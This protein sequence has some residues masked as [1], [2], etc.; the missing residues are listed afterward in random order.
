[1]SFRRL[2]PLVDLEGMQKI[3]QA[4]ILVIGCGGVGSYVIEAL[5]RSGVGT[6][7]LVD[8]DV[9]DACN[10][11]RQLMAFE[12]T[13]G[14]PKVTWLAEHAKKIN[15]N[16]K[17]KT[18]QVRYEETT[19]ERLLS[20]PYHFIVDAIDQVRQKQDLIEE[21][22]KRDIPFISVLGQ[23]NRLSAQGIKI[24]RL[25]QTYQDPIARK[26]RHHF[27]HHPKRKAIRVIFNEQ[28]HEVET[29]GRGC[30]A[31]SIFAP[32][33]AGLMAASVAIQHIIGRDIT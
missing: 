21:A 15:P 16:I 33:S 9:V 8:P 7:T 22:L 32:A 4:H 10:L 24:C 29:A 18:H 25:D 6:L 26:L 27:R 17:V 19:K 28:A 5:I 11:N 31:S 2:L 30:V 12:E 3:E 13:I 20:E 14:E 1:M 23:G